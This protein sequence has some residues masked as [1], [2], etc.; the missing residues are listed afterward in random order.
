MVYI[1]FKGMHVHDQSS[2]TLLILLYILALQLDGETF[3]NI[4]K[5][6]K[7][8]VQAFPPGLLVS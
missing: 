7:K 8:I 1:V 2:L 3:T 6:W 5:H 4:K